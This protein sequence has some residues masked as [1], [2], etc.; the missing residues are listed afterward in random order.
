LRTPIYAAD[1]HGSEGITGVK[2]FEPKQPLAE[3]N[4]VDYLD[5][6]AA[7]RARKKR[8]AGNARP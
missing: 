8:D 6:H 5:P 4:A 7:R 3:G 2:V 1:I